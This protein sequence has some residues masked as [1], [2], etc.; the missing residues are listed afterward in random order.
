MP[1][2]LAG[3]ILLGFGQEHLG[4]ASAGVRIAAARGAQIR[5]VARGAWPSPTGCAVT[6]CC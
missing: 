1:R 5:A 6:A 4:R 2:P 3:N